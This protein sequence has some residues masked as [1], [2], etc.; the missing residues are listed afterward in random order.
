MAVPAE[1]VCEFVVAAELVCDCVGAVTLVRGCWVGRSVESC[2]S[3]GDFSWVEEEGVPTGS[4]LFSRLQVL[5]RGFRNGGV[6]GRCGA[7]G[8]T[9]GCQ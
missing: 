2:G 5:M 1:T 9:F 3:P 6:G 4:L 7:A 8:G